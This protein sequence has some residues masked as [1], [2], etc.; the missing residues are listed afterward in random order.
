MVRLDRL[1]IFSARALLEMSLLSFVA[2]FFLSICPSSVCPLKQR[3]ADACAVLLPC[4]D[5][6]EPGSESTCKP[7]IYDIFIR[8]MIPGVLLRL[9]ASFIKYN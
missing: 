5:T 6:A 2:V 8:C 4:H 7:T 1:D 3:Y 9:Y